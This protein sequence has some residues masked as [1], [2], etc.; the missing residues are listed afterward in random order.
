MN[1]KQKT[2]DVLRRNTT[3]RYTLTEYH[4]V[5]QKAEDAGMSF[6]DF[7]RQMTLKGYVQA[8]NT[9]QDINEIREFKT[10]LVEYRT[11]FSRL[12]NLIKANDPGLNAGIEE[13]KNSI[14]A[15]LEKINL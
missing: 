6:S 5:K 10:L 2:E 14:Q 12:S 11:N 7:C 8:V 15:V 4:T 9:V 1:K 3:V 13:L